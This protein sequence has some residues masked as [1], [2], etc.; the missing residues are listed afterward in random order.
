MNDYLFEAQNRFYGCSAK[1]KLFLGGRRSG[2]TTTLAVE[3][4]EDAAHRG[5]HVEWYSPQQRQATSACTKA[6][7][8]VREFDKEGILKVDV[9]QYTKD[10]IEFRQSGSIKFSTLFRGSRIGSSDDTVVF[11]EI[12]YFGGED[13]RTIINPA[14]NNNPQTKF[15][16]AMTPKGGYEPVERLQNAGF[17]TIPVP[18]RSN[19]R[20]DMD[21]LNHQRNSLSEKEFRR[22]YLLGHAL[23]DH[24]VINHDEDEERI[25]ECVLCDLEVT[26]PLDAEDENIAKAEGWTYGLAQDTSCA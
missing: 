15:L 19:P 25:F 7:E 11:D 3:S 20:V 23:N 4:I 2:K 18:T 9:E 16:A 13:W 24:L 22:E 8:I 17:K 10:R 1:R 26:V 12:N 6:Q 21:Q 5:K 14:F